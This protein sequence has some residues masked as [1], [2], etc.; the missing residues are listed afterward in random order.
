MVETSILFIFKLCNYS[1]GGERALL[2]AVVALWGTPRWLG[3]ARR[4]RRGFLGHGRGRRSAALA[5]LLSKLVCGT[6]WACSYRLSSTSR[7]EVTKICC[8]QT[9][10]V[11]T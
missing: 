9:S 2:G 11:N 1:G 6:P 4:L 10:L 5:M 7:C 3:S 8:F